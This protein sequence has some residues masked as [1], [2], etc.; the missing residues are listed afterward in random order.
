MAEAATSTSPIQP[1]R[2][3]ERGMVRIRWFGVVLGIYLVSATN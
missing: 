1:A 2:R 3:L